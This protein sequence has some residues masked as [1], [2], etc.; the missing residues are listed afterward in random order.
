MLNK[1]FDKRY[2]IQL[3]PFIFHSLSKNEKPF[4][5]EKN[6]INQKN[7]NIDFFYLDQS[8][9]NSYFLDIKQYV[10]WSI[11]KNLCRVFIEKNY[12]NQFKEFYQKEVNIIYLHFIYNLLEKRKF[13]IYKNFLYCL[14]LLLLYLISSFLFNFFL[15]KK[16]FLIF[17]FLF[18]IFFLFI[19]LL[20]KKKQKKIFHDFKKNIFKQTIQKTKKFLGKE[21]FEN[22]LKK[23]KLFIQK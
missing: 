8:K 1:I 9:Y 19:V 3:F 14:N 16:K 22:I 6:I 17:S 21:K 5:T 11:D 23:Q 2:K 4:K 10:V 13:L 12:Y 15:N 7:I 20:I 18:L